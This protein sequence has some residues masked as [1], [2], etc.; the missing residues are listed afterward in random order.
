MTDHH[1]PAANLPRNA[2]SAHIEPSEEFANKSRAVAAEYE[3]LNVF[4]LHL[5][6]S[7]EPSQSLVDAP[8]RRSRTLVR[9]VA[10]DWSL[11]VQL[12]DYASASN[13]LLQASE[14]FNRIG[15]KRQAAY[16]AILLGDCNI[17]KA[18]ARWLEQDH[19]K[20]LAVSMRLGI[21][22]Q[23]QGKYEDAKQHLTSARS[24]FIGESEHRLSAAQCTLTLVQIYTQEGNFAIAETETSDCYI[25]VSGDGGPTW[26]RTL[27]ATAWQ[28]AA[29]T[30]DFSSAEELL[31][32]AREH[33][34]RVGDQQGQASCIYDIGQLRSD[35]GRTQEALEAL[36][37][38]AQIYEQIGA[39]GSWKLAGEKLKFWT[40]CRSRVLWSHLP[41]L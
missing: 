25:R 32:S 33:Y 1:A 3:N 35:Q 9:S 21:I 5:I 39:A 38:A 20:C 7:E 36:R 37:T 23:A 24:A 30:A 40:T 41:V 13:A 29:S 14:I 22:A 17:A 10:P 15:D 18:S 2:A 12:S 11:Y 4:L 16:C 19:I 8:P 34:N 31:F 27:H 26:H 6:N 28:L